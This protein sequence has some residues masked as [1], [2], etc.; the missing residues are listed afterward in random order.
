M[1]TSTEYLKQ[2]LHVV[3]SIDQSM[4]SGDSGP[5]ALESEVNEAGSKGESI[6]KGIGRHLKDMFSVNF[7]GSKS[8][9]S[10]TDKLLNLAEKTPDKNI[11]KLKVLT[12][13]FDG[14]STSL[15]RLSKGMNEL[16]KVKE[17]RV[18][19]AIR[20][21]SMLYEF[22]DKVGDGRKAKKLERSMK[23]F[24]RLGDSLGKVA[25]PIKTISMAL[26]NISLGIVAFAGGILLA[27]KILGLGGASGVFQ[28]LIVAI[29]G[30]G[31]VFGVLALA[32]KVVDKGEDTIKKIGVGMMLLSLGIVS[33]ALAIRVVPV[34]LGTGGNAMS[35]I[36][37]VG[38]ILV[39]TAL[40]F[41]G[42]GL[43]QGPIEK[44]NT[45]AMGM[46][47]GM[48]FLA[49]GV[50]VM[51][52]AARGITVM[53]A[54]EEAV[55]KDGDKRGKFGQLMA[56]IGPG[57]GVMG[58][59]LVSS[60]L[61]FAG[62]GAL[63]PVLL[64]GIGIGIALSVALLLLAVSVKKI[65][66]VS[67]EL[68]T[69]EEIQDSV[70]KTIGGVLSGFLEGIKALA[71]GKTGWQGV[72][73]FIKNS[74]AVM[75][76]VGVL[77]SVSLA[78]SQ[79]AKA[80]TAFAQFESMRVIEGYDNNGKPIFGE[81]INITNVSDNISYSISTFLESILESTE[82][83]TRKKA[84]AIK[85]MGRAL[86][87]RRG[88]L[89]AVI[90]FSEVLKTYA[91]FGEKGEIGFVEMVPDGTDEDGNPKFKQIP[92]TVSIETVVS[93][94]I[95][96]FGSFVTHLT[97]NAEDFEVGRKHGKKMK[98]LAEVLLGKK[99]MGKREKY[100][101]LQ[102][103]QEFADTLMIYSKFGASNEIPILDVDGNPTG[104]SIPVETI[105]KNMLNA[106][107]SFTEE[108]GKNELK[109]ETK[110]A[111]KN[112]K[113]FEDIIKRANKISSS[114]D[115]LAKLSNTLSDLSMNITS[116]SAS[117]TGLDVEKL[118]AVANIG[119]A[120]TYKTNDYASTTE[121]LT[122]PTALASRVG[123]KLEEAKEIQG[124]R[125][126][127][128]RQGSTTVAQE[129]NWEL[130]AAQ[131]GESVGSQIVNAMKNPTDEISIFIYW[132]KSRSN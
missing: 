93:N 111:E 72:K 112:L 15:P 39:F 60:A 104:E 85:K 96:S 1:Q 2:I 59:I 69:K 118:N 31:M 103:I 123:D 16:G 57:L 100:G 50:T 113:R 38:G 67:S 94:I 53:G 7:K 48:M 49:A 8:F 56:N 99:G 5:V 10:F 126:A 88:I 14:L 81:K 42:L 74:A 41:A 54:G 25:K 82:G 132:W 61:F 122:K 131:I 80:L 58:I 71:G 32:N 51:A 78:L 116:L 127:E 33:F 4:K 3:A 84:K 70:G 52:L 11:D 65:V 90:Q 114:M 45:V 6:F 26:I 105:A 24:E 124:Q 128:R 121:D 43:L 130:I 73:N 86:T 35:G 13:S 117:L 20:N 95:D 34:I 120:Y 89:T 64:P 40:I 36:L 115:G 129:P 83:L 97:A 79:F 109:T 19:A 37:A 101:L 44:G 87:G 125:T 27:G 47:L 76:G 75:M 23:L 110:A 119:T 77:L 107:V 18:A 9:F 30:I 21:L 98:R 92:Q 22:L 12:D 68:G 28:F 102:P 46:G 17:K 66:N 55:N 91:K 108:L 63:A 106:L 29:L 62:L